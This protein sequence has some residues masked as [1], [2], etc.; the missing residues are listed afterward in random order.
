[1]LQYYKD[2]LMVVG[3]LDE[4]KN[5]CGTGNKNK[6]IIWILTYERINKAFLN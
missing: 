1:M 6:L 2:H 5:H 4:K 3:D